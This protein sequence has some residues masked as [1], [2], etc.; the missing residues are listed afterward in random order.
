VTKS[1]RIP[2][3]T[4]LSF[5]QEDAPAGDITSDAI[6]GDQQCQARIVVQEGGVIAG[7]D[8]AATLFRAHGT[9][10]SPCVLD[11]DAVDAGTVLATIEGPARAVLLVERTALN[12]IGRMS[13]I[14]TMTRHLQAIVEMVQPGC[15]IASTRKTAPGLRLL[16]KKAVI[17]GGGDPHRMTLSDGVLI[18]DNHLALVPLEDAIHA[19]RS[20][21]RYKKVEVEVQNPADALRA[22]RAGAD[23]ILLDNMSPSGIKETVSFLQQ[24]GLREGLL[25]EVSG[26]INGENLRDYA[27]E[28]VDLISIG[29]LTHSVKNL[30]VSLEILP[31]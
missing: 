5:I 15:R 14:A 11:G 28:G 7:I 10:M 30:D 25:I 16:D 2:L 31:G 26:G 24:T 20:H 3:D 27:L 12:I 29:A 1:P 9:R 21:T 23:I 13:G 18:K 17:L 8:E 22:A 4:L 19:A 6:L